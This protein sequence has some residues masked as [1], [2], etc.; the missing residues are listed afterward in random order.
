MKGKRSYGDGGI[1]E[2]GENSWRLRYRVNGKRFSKTFR[3]S[4]SDARKELRRL[5]R[6]G[7]T[8]EHV[9]PAKITLAEW[10]DRWIALLERQPND[11]EGEG[12]RKRGLVNRRTLE[13]YEELLRCHVKPTLGRRPLQQL[14][15]SEID[16]LYHK[17]EGHLSPRTVHHVHT[18][19]G[20][21]CK[22]AVRK[23]L[24]SSDPVARAEAPSP[25]ESEAGTVLEEEQL[26]T[27]VDGFRGSVLFPIVATLAFT[28]ARRN[29]VLGLRWADLDAKNK[30]LRI[31]RAVEKTKKYGLAL[32]EPK[33]A[34]HK[35]TITVD[36]NLIELL[37]AEREKHLRIRAG[38]PDGVTVD[39]SLVKLPDDGLMFPN[40]PAVGEGF[41][42]TKLRNPN[43]TTKELGRKAADLGFPG[44]RPCHDLRCTHE[45]LLLDRCVPVHVVA[46]RC[47]HDPAVL[48]RNYAKRTRKADISAAAEIGAL[49]KGTLGR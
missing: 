20:A 26:R 33:R 45:T 29:E 37:V 48:L 19:L 40:P 34:R 38:V 39:L 32:K 17:L 28:G 1:D 2:R 44:I 5:I 43:N 18:V 4:P 9:S 11:N 24:I 36:D 15:G 23:G 6:S 47:G 30:T 25:G 35:R 13:R 21:C 22:V 41:S 31:E 16:D 46:A 12:R 49:T 10:I 14:Q 3:G 8:G 42:F 27:L 7:D